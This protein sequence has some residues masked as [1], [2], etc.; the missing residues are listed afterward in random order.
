MKKT[1]VS[2]LLAVVMLMAVMT[3]C[4]GQ[5]NTQGDA[6]KTVA[7]AENSAAP[8]SSN[9][10]FKVGFPWLMTSD[11]TFVAIQN[12]VKAACEA[13]GGELVLENW[14]YT[15]DG[16]V[17]CSEKLI[18]QGVDGLIL[19]PTSDSIAPKLQKMCEDAKIPFVFPYR[20]I[21]DPKIKASVEASPYYVGNSMENDEDFAYEAIKRLAG[22]GVKNLA[23]LGL[24]KGD[25]SGDRRDMGINKAAKEFGVK[26]LAETRGLAQGSDATKAVESFI[27]AYPEMDGIFIVG[28]AITPGILQGTTKALDMHGKA[29]KVKVG[30]I[31]FTAGMADEFNKGYLTLAAGGNMV[32]DPTLTSIMLINKIKGTPLSDKPFTIYVNVMFLESAQQANDY[33]KYVEGDVPPFSKEEMQKGMFKFNDSSIT[34]ENIKKIAQNYSLEDIMNRHKDLVK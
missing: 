1:V 15:P 22:K 12:S 29:G 16:L 4:G 34:A 2:I 27:A 28:A 6:G 24:P 8:T 30:M 21:V 11:P 31:D 9:K 33:F 14:N 7:S 3:G 17:T 13:A 19:I 5:K 18:S 20:F 23:I 32:A 10:P 25:I 26:I